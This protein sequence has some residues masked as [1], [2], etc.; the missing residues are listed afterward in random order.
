VTL[1]GVEV[2]HSVWLTARDGTRLVS[3]VYRPDRPGEYPVLVYR[4]LGPRATIAQAAPC[5]AARAADRGYVVVVQ[6]A[7]GCGDS[8]GEYRPLRHEGEDGFDTVEWAATLPGSSGDVAMFGQSYSATVQ[9]QAAAACPP[10][11][12]TIVPVYGMP[13][14]YR[15]HYFNNGALELNNLM[16]YTAYY[17]RQALRR[18]GLPDDS[19]DDLLAERLPEWPLRPLRDDVLRTLPLQRLVDRFKLCAPFL[20]ED[21]RCGADPRY[22]QDADARLAWSQIRVPVLHVG[23]WYD[24]YL[25]DTIAMY[26]G[27]SRHATTPSARQNQCLLIAPF[28]H[29]ASFGGPNL[30]NA[31]ELDFGPQAHLDAWEVSMAWFDHVLKAG[32]PARERFPAARVFVTG[33]NQWRDEEC[34]PVD[35]AVRTA[36]YLSG[37]TAANGSSGAGRLSW[38]APTTAEPPDSYLYDPL[39]PVPTL[40]GR[41]LARAAGPMDR[42]PVESR[43]DVLVYTSDA[44]DHPIEAVGQVTVVVYASSSAPDTDFVASLVDVYPDESAQLIADGIV[45]ARHQA[46]TGDSRPLEPGRPREF[47]IDLWSIGHVFAAGHRIRLEVTS[48]SF[49]RWNRNLNTGLPLLSEEVPVEAAQT[50]YHDPDRPS[51]MMLPLRV[52][53]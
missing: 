20:E 41:L 1:P 31:G 21:L 40:G 35:D 27:I 24:S 12:R 36:V 15:N 26:E 37:E 46:V 52:R 45:R 47:C 30:G 5:R 23:S 48:S 16:A 42:R 29:T 13:T 38:H 11:L 51:R 19:L 8:E 14:A 9:Y 7:R 34:W 6:E 10:H 4:S 33:E 28:A 39:D 53:S 22:W 32:R 49:P 3:D 50:V 25:Y 44:L 43:D 17:A 18:D 2:L